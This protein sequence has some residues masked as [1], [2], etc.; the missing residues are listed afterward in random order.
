MRIVAPIE[1]ATKTCTPV[2]FR[3]QSEL[4]Y[5]LNRGCVADPSALGL[6]VQHKL[7]LCRF[8]S[9]ASGGSFV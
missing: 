2:Q 1:Y 3:L 6:V 9:D 7:A 5:L 4:K 8:G